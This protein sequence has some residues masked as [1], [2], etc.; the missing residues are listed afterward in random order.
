MSITRTSKDVALRLANH[1]AV[2]S[3]VED[4]ILLAGS[5]RSGTTW[6]S[7]ILAQ[8]DGY[9]FM[10]EPLLIHNNPSVTNHGFGWR[11]CLSPGEEHPEVEAYL[12]RVFTGRLG[13]GPWWHFT[14]STSLN[15]MKEHVTHRKLVVK[16]CRAGRM[17]NW[18]AS[19]FAFRSIVFIVR[20]PCAVV[21]SLI[22]RGGWNPLEPDPYPGR[23]RTP[24]ALLLDIPED[25]LQE[26]GDFLRGINTKHEIIAA[27]WALD[28]YFPFRYHEGVHQDWTLV[29][30]EDLMTNPETT[31]LTICDALGADVSIEDLQLR[32]A[33][34]Y[35]SKTLKSNDASTQNTKW[36]RKLTPTQIDDVLAIVERFDLQDLAAE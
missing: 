15:R 20:H 21:S 34:R 17:L 32:Q 28:H 1:V 31:A 23:D 33:S 36:K 11:T 27:T 9:R 18:I 10:N 29:R 19:R 30:Y 12:R 13:L 22:E 3:K 2:R 24:E 16:L 7:E 35:A 6:I 4:T 14:T 26:H 5:P 8:L 25:V